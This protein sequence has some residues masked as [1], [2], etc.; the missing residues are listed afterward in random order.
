MHS[1]RDV[2]SLRYESIKS[3]EEYLFVLQRNLSTIMQHPYGREKPKLLQQ[4]GA[5]ESTGAESRFKS[6]LNIYIY[7][8]C[9]NKTVEE[10]LIR[11]ILNHEL[12]IIEQSPPKRVASSVNKGKWTNWEKLLFTSTRKFLDARPIFQRR[13]FDIRTEKQHFSVEIVREIRHGSRRGRPSRLGCRGTR[14]KRTI[15]ERSIK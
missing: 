9:E 1:L 3:T 12:P 6:Q 15:D 8:I 2:S 13:G 14:S 5:T 4:P 7:H 10:H 11:T